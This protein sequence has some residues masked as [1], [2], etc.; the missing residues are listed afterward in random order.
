MN[1]K[2]L[3]VTL[4]LSVFVLNVYAQNELNPYKYI[5]VPKKFDFL[6][7]ENQYRVNSYTKFLFD[8]EGIRYFMMMVI[9]LKIL[10]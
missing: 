5:I 1:L 2:S 9:F 3:L 8:K 6:K 10:S 4:V 7:K